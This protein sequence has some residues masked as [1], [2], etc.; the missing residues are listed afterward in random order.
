MIALWFR[1]S[2]FASYSRQSNQRCNAMIAL[3]F[4]GSEFASYSRQALGIDRSR[5]LANLTDV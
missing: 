4:R 3:W 1:G 5:V 2:E